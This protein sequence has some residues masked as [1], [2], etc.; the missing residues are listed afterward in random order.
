MNNF[1]HF[2][3]FNAESSLESKKLIRKVYASSR[4]KEAVS[5]D[6][7]EA[8]MILLDGFPL[9]WY[10]YSGISGIDGWGGGGGGGWDPVCPSE[11]NVLK[12]FCRSESEKCAFGVDTACRNVQACCGTDAGP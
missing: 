11:P 6:S 12:E 10:G 7:V 3:G 1:N 5:T 9:D 2:P 4:Y 8:S